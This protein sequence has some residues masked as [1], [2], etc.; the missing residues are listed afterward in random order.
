M[1]SLQRLFFFFVL[2]LDF[3]I[4][5]QSSNL[6]FDFD[7]ANFKGFDGK[8]KV[9]FYF[10]IYQ[11]SLKKVIKDNLLISNATLQIQVLDEQ[12]NIVFSKH[13]KLESVEDSTLKEQNLIGMIQFELS[14]Q[15][16]KLIIDAKDSFDTSNVFSTIIDFI[17]PDF[18]NSKLAVSDIELA[19]RIIKTSDTNSVFY[20]N[21]LEVEPNPTKVFSMNSPVVYYYAEIYSNTD[22]V[23]TEYKIINSTGEM[24]YSKSKNFNSKGNS[25]V[26][27]GTINISDFASGVYSF[28]IEAKDGRESKSVSKKFYVYNPSK[29]DTNQNV[30]QSS[31]EI[32]QSEFLSLSEE[33]LNL[34]YRKSEYIASETE[35]SDWK[36]LTE[37]E[38]K[39]KF[40]HN[41]W[42]SRDEFPSTPVNETKIAYF[43]RVDYSQSKFSGLSNKEGW[44]TDRG[45]VYI[46]YGK[47]SEIERYPNESEKKPYEIWRYENI[48]GGVV[49]I[50]ADLS[51]YSDYKLIHSTKRGEVS[52]PNWEEKITQ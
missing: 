26:D 44:R 49:F 48:E 22:K 38:A 23:N 33:E 41:F 30:A 10:S 15:K 25:I 37:P 51:G 36:K 47:P 16:Y 28:I 52:L 7:Y 42:K 8:T 20:K 14:P 3:S 24:K 45:R 21:T 32:L 27:I 4:F 5:A 19:N 11:P 9:E 29:I 12:N 17:L 2:I 39:R 1:S 46:V 50:F 13:G 40:L 31:G 18:G 34:L 43:D 6:K 35:K